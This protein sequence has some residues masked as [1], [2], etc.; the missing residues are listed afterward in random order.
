MAVQK[1]ATNCD[2]YQRTKLS[3]KK[4]GRFSPKLYLKIPWN[5]ICVDIVGPYKIH[6]KGKDNL[7]LK[8][9]TMIDPVTSWFEITQY[10]NKKR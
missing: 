7:I 6:S 5:K 8:S 1:E 10:K 2:T 9:L 3:T 4:Y